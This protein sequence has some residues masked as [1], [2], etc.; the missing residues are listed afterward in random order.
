[1]CGARFARPIS[2]SK[3]EITSRFQKLETCLLSW[4]WGGGGGGEGGKK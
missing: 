1:M 4:G 3:L 2:S